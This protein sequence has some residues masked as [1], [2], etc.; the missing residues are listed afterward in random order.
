MAVT[1]QQVACGLAGGLS[2]PGADEAASAEA[3]AGADA[4]ADVAAAEVRMQVLEWGCRFDGGKKRE[5]LWGR[6]CGGR[7]G[8][9]GEATA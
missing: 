9:R 1:A 4:V 7:P 3:E 5:I 8:L 6:R 2:G